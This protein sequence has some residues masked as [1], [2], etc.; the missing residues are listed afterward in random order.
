MVDL[1]LTRRTGHWSG[2]NAAALVVAGAGVLLGRPGLVLAGV[3][4]VGLAAYAGAGTPP[5]VRLGVERTL[6]TTTPDR[7]EVVAVRVAVTNE[8]ESLLPDLRV[9]DGVPAGLAV[10]DG[11]PRHATALRPG[12][13]A[14]FSYTVRAERG[15]HPFDPAYVV[16]RDASGSS[17]RRIEVGSDDELRCVPPLPEPVSVP[18]RATASGITGETAVDEGGP[19]TAFYAV[20]EY[21]R[22][23][24]PNRIDWNRAARTGQFSTVEFQRERSASVVV[25]VDAREASYVAPAATDPPAVEH[26]LEAAGSVFEG[27]R[28]AGDRVGLAA[29]A[30]EVCWLAPAA[31]EDHRLIAR[32]TL[33]THPALA[34]TAPE[35]PFF[36]TLRLAQLRRRLP[37][38]AQVVFCTPL[39][40]DYPVRVARRLDAA[41]NRVTVVAPDPTGGESSGRRLARVERSLRCSTLREVGIPVVDW[42]ED[43]LR[44]TVANA[45]RRWSA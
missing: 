35:E 19:G 33:A 42:G 27:R 25:L 45:V 31:G 3:V 24:P 18:L 41:G 40:D 20:R 14:R 23:D 9:V 7:D 34:P 43:S 13:T 10:E 22:G 16:A 8:G 29:L 38:N 15:V 17:E 11:S 28:L 1:P 39:V 21:R 5:E 44:A 30:P 36:G 37:A 26:C 6:S 2:V 32:E 12:K 4:A